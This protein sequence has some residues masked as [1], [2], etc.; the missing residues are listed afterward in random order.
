MLSNK[1]IHNLREILYITTIWIIATFFFVF[2]KFH[3]VP[4]KLLSVYLQADHFVSTGLVY[5]MS[6][7][8]A[9]P[10]GLLLGFLHTFI[11]PRLSR[12]KNVF[13]N[14]LLRSCI[15][16][17]LSATTLLFTSYIDSLQYKNNLDVVPR[18]LTYKTLLGI[19]IYMLVTENL[20]SLFIMLRRNLGRNYFRNIIANTY[21]NPKEEM[22]VFMFLDME[23][24][25]PTVYKLGN[26]NFSRYLQDCFYDLSD[27]VLE[28]Q[29]NIY[30]F[31]GDEAIITWR[32]S[33]GF[34]FKKCIDLYFAYIDILKLKENYYKSTYGCLPKFR[35]AIHVGT[36]STAL[37]GDYKR[38]LAFHGD[39]LNLCSRLQSVCKENLARV[40]VSYDFLSMIKD[41][42][43]YII[44]PVTI[45]Y[46]KGIPSEQ[47]A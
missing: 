5:V 17:I 43:N 26:L 45:N 9:F 15:F 32:V 30:Q 41:Q 19:F 44:E 4:E 13:F 11:Y 16:V 2:I 36:V 46:L 37:V 34:E 12:N 27:I 28:Y 20:V 38:E 25:T 35:C 39:V 40:L 29:A 10:L 3:D 7:F 6:L 47:Q 23:N 8:I 21:R 24:S 1:L 33:N 14:I 22:R 18:I 31:V 42:T